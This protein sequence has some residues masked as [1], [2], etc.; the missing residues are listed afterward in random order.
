MR[1]VEGKTNFS[2]TFW[3]VSQS[4]LLG[5]FL[6]RYLFDPYYSIF[7]LAIHAFEVPHLKSTRNRIDASRKKST[8]KR[9][10]SGKIKV[11]GGGEWG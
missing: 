9:T 8:R 1:F 2:G 4:T 7:S 5:K 10:A 6:T 11:K 3:H